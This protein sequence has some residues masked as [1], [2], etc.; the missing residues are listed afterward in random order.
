MRTVSQQPE[1]LCGKR[2]H[3]HHDDFSYSPL[4]TNLPIILPNHIIHQSSNQ[5]FQSII[6]KS[7][8]HCFQSIIRQSIIPSNP[9]IHK[10]YFLIH[11]PKII[12]FAIFPIHYPTII[13]SL[14]LRQY[15]MI[16]QSFF[17]IFTNHTTI[18]CHQINYS[19]IIQSSAIQI[20]FTNHRTIQCHPIHYSLIVQPFSAIQTIIHPSY[21]HSVPHCPTTDS[22]HSTTSNSYLL[23]LHPIQ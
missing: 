22:T 6:H 15:P 20:L 19:P 21:K 3:L 11:Y 13:L 18:Q 17:P 7:I 4:F 2:V 1:I 16:I 8:N 5:S 14:F 10:Y 9:L 23:M 12:V